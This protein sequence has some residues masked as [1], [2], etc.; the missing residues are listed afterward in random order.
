MDPAQRIAELEAELAALRAEMQDFSYT[1][2]HDLRAS[3]RHVLSYAQLVQEDAGEQLAP[4]VQGF[5]ATMA[6]SARHMGALM[7]GLMEL[8]RLGTVPLQPQPLPLRPLLQELWQEARAGHAGRDL[9]WQLA[10]DLPVVQADAAL[11]RLSLLQLLGNALKFSAPR[12]QAVV[13]VEGRVDAAA[14]MAELHIRDNGVGFNPALQ[15][16]LFRPFQRLHT[17]RQFPGIGMGLALVRKSL[18]RMG[19]S[20]S[21]QGT[22]DAGCCIRLRLPLAR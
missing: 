4:Q 2:S 17:V 5:L 12:T 20:V 15:D 3:L 13:A 18:Q 6:D 22:P 1:V 8:N 9:E 19:G 10:G 7:D 14:A 11:L 16:K 21:A